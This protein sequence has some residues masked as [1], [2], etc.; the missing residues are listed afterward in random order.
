MIEDSGTVQ[1]KKIYELTEI[2]DERN[3]QA[4][5]AADGKNSKPVIVIDGRGYERVKPNNHNI[6]DLTEIIEDDPSADQFDD[7]VIKRA[8]EIIEKIAREVVPEIAERVIREEIGKI[9]TTGKK[10]ST[11]QD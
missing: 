10:H 3:G 4:R 5:K 6:H 8:T 1:D 2:Y 9:K 7:L 11:D